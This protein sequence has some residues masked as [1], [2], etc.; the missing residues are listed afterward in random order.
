MEIVRHNQ[1][2]IHS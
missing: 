1:E 2:I